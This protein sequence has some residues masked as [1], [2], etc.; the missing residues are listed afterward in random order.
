VLLWFY[1]GLRETLIFSVINLILFVLT[2]FVVPLI[3]LGQKTLMD[4][5]AGSF[6]LMRKNWYEAAA[7]AAFLGVIVCG[8]F[9]TYLL[10][11]AAYGMVTPLAMYYRP[12]DPWLA[13]GLIYY[14]ALF[15]VSFVLATVAGIATLEIYTAAKT[16]QMPKSAGTGPTG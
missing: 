10:I 9:L 12:T 1:P 11:Q 7:C 2:P 13:L 8:V 6:A 4:A 3:V 14:L 16:G 5:V 15:S